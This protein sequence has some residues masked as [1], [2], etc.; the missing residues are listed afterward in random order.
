ML[1]AFMLTVLVIMK[2]E[3]MR[4]LSANFFI[5]KIKTESSLN[6]GLKRNMG[7]TRLMLNL[8]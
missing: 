2:N 1:V 6:V 5:L 4:S 8:I 7:K 3:K